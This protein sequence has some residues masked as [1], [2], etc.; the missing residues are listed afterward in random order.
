M[1]DDNAKTN[2]SGGSTGIAVLAQFDKEASQTRDYCVAKY[3][4]LRA[5][6]PD[7][8]L[9][10]ERF[11]GMTIKLSHH[12]NCCRLGRG[13]MIWNGTG[14]AGLLIGGCG[15]YFFCN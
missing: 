13:K 6:P 1:K 14:V 4:T 5:A 7:P 12:R 2:D 10:K 9:R 3:A 15:T 11:L 8:S